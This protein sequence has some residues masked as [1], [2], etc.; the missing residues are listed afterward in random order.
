[1]S[2]ND[3][4]TIPLVDLG[5]QYQS[6]KPAV[7]EAIANILDGMHLFLGE[8]V[9]GFE[10]EFADFCGA[11]H[12]IGVGSGTDALVLALRAA[13]VGPGDEVLTVSNTFIAT[14]EAIYLV[15]ATPV[16]VD[17]DP[18]T[19]TMDPHQIEAH[20]TPKTRAILPVHLYGQLADME[21]ICA[22][23]RRH[24]LVVIED[25]C[26][27]H[28]ATRRSQRA[29]TFGDLGCFSFYFSKNLGAYGE[30]G[31]VVTNN[32]DLA[33]AVAQLRN[34]GSLDKYQHTV[35]G[36]NS[37]LD[38]IQAAVLRIKLRQLERWNQQRREHA[39]QYRQLLA[40][41]GVTTPIDPGDQSHVYHLFVIRSEHREPLR[42]SLEDAG[43]ATGIHYPV[44]VH[45]QPAWT[46]HGYA[47]VR[48]PVTEE[49]TE[50][51]LTLP[52]YPELTNAQIAYVA[53]AVER[54]LSDFRG[55]T[56]G[57]APIRPTLRR[58]V[59]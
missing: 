33:Q 44:P 5:A 47:P 48:L 49:L 4:Q 24:S 15:G 59:A 29:G 56:G 31:A 26:Q 52:M 8:Q 10:R 22:I 55:E 23:A 58:Q 16:L 21:R 6:I 11:R 27:A 53:D 38:E 50:Q 3:R 28:G 12:C 20:L 30:A 51:I 13:G 14:V 40:A 46:A 32:A 41:S 57:R 42:A 25:A 9:T 54:C 37:R 39:A 19:Y 2:V 43:V 18:D 7:L 35:L 1:M 17:I 36:L 34:H 45:Q